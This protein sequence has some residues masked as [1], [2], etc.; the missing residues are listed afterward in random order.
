MGG[1]TESNGRNNDGRSG[2]E[3]M[4]DAA[5][6]TTWVVAATAVLSVLLAALTY[7]ANRA[8]S[9]TEVAVAHESRH[10][11]TESDVEHIEVSIRENNKIVQSQLAAIHEMSI[12]TLKH[13]IEE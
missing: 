12:L 7:G 6:V 8:A 9:Y 10:V 11:V 1:S 4:S 2:Y 13:V 3:I 5:K